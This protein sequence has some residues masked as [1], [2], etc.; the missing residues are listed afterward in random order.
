MDSAF[1]AR[2]EYELEQNNHKGAWDAWHPAHIELVVEL[3]HH[4]SKLTNALKSENK[5]LVAEYSADIANLAMKTHELF[6]K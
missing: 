2:M 6:G 4:I 3:L 5:H 1:I